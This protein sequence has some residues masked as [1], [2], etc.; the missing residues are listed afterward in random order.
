[1]KQRNDSVIQK[2]RL[3][4]TMKPKRERKAMDHKGRFRELSNLVKHNNIRIIEVP[5]HEERDKRPEGLFK[6]IMAENFPKSGEGHR[7]KNPR[8]TENSY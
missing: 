5:E 8:S 4:K 1:M 7:H 2:I 6:Q 3:W